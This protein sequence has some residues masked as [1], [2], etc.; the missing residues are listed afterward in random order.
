[1]RLIKTLAAVAVLIAPA[2]LMA[3]PAQALTSKQYE[4]QGRGT[5][6]NSTG[7]RVSRGMHRHYRYGSHHHRMR[8][9]HR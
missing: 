6:L 5:Y 1:M 8:R 3:A 2:V 7:S 9:H 4:H